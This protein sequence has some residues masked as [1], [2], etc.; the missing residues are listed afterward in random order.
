M[1]NVSQWLETIKNAV[2]GKDMRSA[3]YDCLYTLFYE[4][5]GFFATKD[6]MYNFTTNYTLDLHPDWAL[7]TK[8]FENYHRGSSTSGD[9]A[10]PITLTYDI[11]DPDDGDSLLVWVDY[12]LY[13]KDVDYYM[14]MA[15]E[16]LYI[17][18]FYTKPE[19]G[20]K[21]ILQVWH[22][23]QVLSGAEVVGTVTLVSDGSTSNTV[24]G[25]AEEIT[26]EEDSA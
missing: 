21:I 14:T 25:L 26:D 15:G 10:T 9:I 6:S 5:E 19:N 13:K 20:S 23:T 17:V 11:Y 1:S 18:N 4:N 24:A 3:I 2:Y 22:K 16:H 7:D 12:N 8:I